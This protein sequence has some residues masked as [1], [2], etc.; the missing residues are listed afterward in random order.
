MEGADG[1]DG[2]WGKGVEVSFKSLPV[3]G[4]DEDEGL[5]VFGC[6]LSGVGEICGGC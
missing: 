3:R 1:V 4:G 6:D 2:W 5:E